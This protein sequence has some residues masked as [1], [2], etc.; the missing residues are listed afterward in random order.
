M[1]KEVSKWPFV[2]AVLLY[3]ANVDYLIIPFVL[4]PLK[5]S[6]WAMFFVAAALANLEIVGGFYFWRWFAWTWLPSTEPVK[7][8]VAFT[9][10]VIGELRKQGLLETIK[11][12]ALRTFRWATDPDS[13]FIR[14]IKRW[15]HIGMFCLGAESLISGGRLVG[16]VICAS[17]K[18]K[19]GL[20]SLIIG[21]TIHVAISVGTWKLFFY[22]WD[23]HKGWLILFGVITLLF[24]ARG[25]FRKKLKREQLLPKIP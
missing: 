1:K 2:W 17:T 5:L 13:Q 10:S 18:W 24:M 6:F 15:E 16:T 8:T 23:E 4:E 19:N 3:S 25:Y 12:R 22:L 9:K 21:N 11:N 7:D 20:Y 14:F